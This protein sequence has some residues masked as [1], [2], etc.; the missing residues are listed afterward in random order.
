MGRVSVTECAR[1]RDVITESELCCWDFSC[2]VGSQGWGTRRVETRRAPGAERGTY[3]P[4][5]VA[6]S[7]GS[8]L[9]S[10]DVQV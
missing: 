2:A 5:A 1:C 8:L 9:R 6:L 10:Q 3:T 7:A 4:Q